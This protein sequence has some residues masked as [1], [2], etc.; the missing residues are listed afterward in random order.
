MVGG[1]DDRGRFLFDFFRMH[2]VYW[3]PL[4]V[5]KQNTSPSSLAITIAPFGHGRRADK[6]APCFILPTF[7]PVVRFKP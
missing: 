5:P 1:G 6:I 3:V 2:M 4:G 7:S